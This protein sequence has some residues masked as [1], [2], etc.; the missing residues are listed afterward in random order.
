VVLTRVVISESARATE[1]RL[2]KLLGVDPTEVREYV[3]AILEDRLWRAGETPKRRTGF[4]FK[5]GTHGGTW[6]RDPEGTDVLP[7]GIHPPP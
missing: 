6:I 2:A 1:E 5:R 4:T 3:L 7:V